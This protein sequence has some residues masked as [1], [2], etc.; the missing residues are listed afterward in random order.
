MSA[1]GTWEFSSLPPGKKLIS[2]KW[3]YKIKLKS[4][5]KI[6]RFKARL[7]AK[8]FTQ[9]QLDV[10]NA[11]LYGDLMEEVYMKSL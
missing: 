6:E 1:N 3:V 5:G 2:S 9:R 10:N 7:V 11:F 8:G 4:D